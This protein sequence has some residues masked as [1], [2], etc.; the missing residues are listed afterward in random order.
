M[1]RWYVAL[2]VV[3]AMSVSA[4]APAHAQKWFDGLYLGLHTGAGWGDHDRET[5]F[6]FQNSYSSDGWLFGGHL[7]FSVQNG[8]FVFGLE[9]DIAGTT[10]RGDDA[11]VGGTKDQSQ[12]DH[13]WSVR[14]RVGYV[15]MPQLLVFATAGWGFADI[16]HVNFSSPGCC[17]THGVDGFTWGGGIQWALNNVL[18]VRAEYRNYDFGSY[19]VSNAPGLADFSVDNTR[20]PSRSV[21]ACASRAAE[22]GLQPSIVRISE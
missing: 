18:S 13:L 10:I 8:P 22:I 4:P 21:S 5:I 17:G 12:F 20:R 1:R 2:A 14:G 3:G 7:G 6:G 16:K 15:V 9:G 19:S 11:G